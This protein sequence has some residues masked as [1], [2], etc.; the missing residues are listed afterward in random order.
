VNVMTGGGGKGGDDLDQRGF[1]PVKFLASELC[2]DVSCFYINF[3]T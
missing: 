3:Y 1:G 2:E